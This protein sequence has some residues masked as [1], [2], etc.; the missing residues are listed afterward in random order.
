M[1]LFAS[2]DY[3]AHDFIELE[4]ASVTV[5]RVTI[6]TDWKAIGVRERRGFHALTPHKTGELYYF[7]M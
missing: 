6:Q 4:S 7:D 1:I 5:R 3:T 2:F